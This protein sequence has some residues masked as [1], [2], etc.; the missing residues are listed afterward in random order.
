[1]RFSN[2]NVYEKLGFE[3]IRETGPNYFWHKKYGE[4]IPRYKSQKRNLAKL[5]GE[6]YNPAETEV[7][8]MTRNKYYR[9]FD[10]GNLVYEMKG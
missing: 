10:C 7:E 6:A 1:M 5:L 2:G 9:C 8:N 4:I 3:L